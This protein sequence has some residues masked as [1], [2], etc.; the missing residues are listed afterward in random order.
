M[1]GEGIAGALRGRKTGADY[2]VR[3]LKRPEIDGI[4]N[5]FGAAAKR[6]SQPP[7]AI[8]ICADLSG[9]ICTA[10]GVT[11]HGSADQCRP[12]Y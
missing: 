4:A 11:A 9:E 1:T 12:R 6:P 7:Q 2:R 5:P 10:L 8:P 3:C